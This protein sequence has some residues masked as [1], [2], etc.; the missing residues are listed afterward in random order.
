MPSYAG[1]SYISGIS[2]TLRE[3]QDRQLLFGQDPSDL[4]CHNILTKNGGD[5]NTPKDSLLGCIL[6]NWSKFRQDGLREKINCLLQY[7]MV[8]I[9]TREPRNL[10]KK[11]VIELQYPLVAG[12]I[13]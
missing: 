13:V 5:Y 12:P 8:P 7:C 2:G 10:A 3:P 9:Q 4:S 11:W 6:A 1:P